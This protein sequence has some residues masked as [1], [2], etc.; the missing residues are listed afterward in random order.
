MIG[1][2]TFTDGD[3]QSGGLRYAIIEVKN[4][5]GSPGADP[6]G[7]AILHYID[8]TKSSATK[9]PG[10]RFPCIL[11]TLFGEYRSPHLVHV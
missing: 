7:Q 6:H 10:F 1:E 4:E 8:S 11:I 5:I 2:T 9:L 3:I